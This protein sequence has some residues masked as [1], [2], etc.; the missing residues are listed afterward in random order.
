VEKCNQAAIDASS[1]NVSC[2][3]LPP[4]FFTGLKNIKS[5]KLSILQISN[6][7]S[8]DCKSVSPRIDEMR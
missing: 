7:Q 8:L 4:Y 2:S 5:E 6:I 3:S 1:W